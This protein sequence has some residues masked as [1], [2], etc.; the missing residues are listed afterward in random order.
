MRHLKAGR[1]LNRNSEHRLALMRNLSRAL[2]MHERIVTT[3]AKAKALRPFI[4]K[5]ITL[6]KKAAGTSDRVQA[7]HYRRLAIQIL[8]P[9][10]DAGMYTKQDTPIEDRAVNSLIK[11]LFNEVG[12]RYVDR[13]GGYTRILKR[14]VRRLGD[15]GETALIE[16]LAK[17]ETK[18]KKQRSAPAPRVEPTPTPV[19]TPT[20]T[21]TATE[22]PATEP[23]NPTPAS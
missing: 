5:L 21:P 22:T 16:L 23:T 15:A 17:G 19:P 8:G 2:I 12:P 4:E 18:P 1:K 20:P 13:P 14:H 3:V 9:T 11:K 7:L 6:A 10:H